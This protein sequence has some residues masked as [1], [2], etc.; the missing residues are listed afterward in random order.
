MNSIL[1]FILRG[2]SKRREKSKAKRLKIKIFMGFQILE[3]FKR[4]NKYNEVMQYLQVHFHI[5]F[6][7][8]TKLFL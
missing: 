8:L 2:L 4:K 7:S 6:D 3:G 1:N 5:S